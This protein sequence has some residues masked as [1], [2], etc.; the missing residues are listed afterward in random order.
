MMGLAFA[1]T[2]PGLAVGVVLFWI[3]STMVRRFA[4][5]TLLPERWRGP[6]GRPAGRSPAGVAVDVFTG[7]VNTG[8]AAELEE[9]SAEAMRRDEEGDAAPPRSRVD[10]GSGRA[11]IVLPKA[12]AGA[13]GRS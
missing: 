1:L 2:L 6:A 13:D 4:R 11:V 9:R 5:S 10:L 8:K 3:A 7:A 12:P